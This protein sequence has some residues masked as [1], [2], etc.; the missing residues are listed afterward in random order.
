MRE[1]ADVVIIGAG[2]AG[3]A[4]ARVLDR[5]PAAASRRVL[6]LE[7][8]A[9]VGGRVATDNIDGFLLDRGFQVYL[10]AY[11]TGK[12][13]LD[14]EAL[15]LKPFA[16]GALIFMDGKLRKFV[17][18][19][20]QP[21]A[22]PAMAFSPVCSL[23]DKFRLLKL[24]RLVTSVPPEELL[25]QDPVESIDYLRRFGFSDDCIAHF[26]RPFYS[27]VF[28]EKDLTTTSRFLKYTF[29]MFARGK[30]VLPAAGM[31]AIPRQLAARL[32]HVVLELATPVIGITDKSA[33]DGGLAEQIVHTASGR[34][35]HARA[36]IVATEMPTAQRLIEGPHSMRILPAPRTTTCLYFTTTTAPTDLPLLVL[37]GQPA[38]GPINHL[39]VLTNVV[40]SYAPAKGKTRPHLISATAFTHETDDEKL[41]RQAKD[42]LTTWFG[43]PVQ[44]WTH[45]HTTRIPYALPNTDTRLAP[46]WPVD[47][48]VRPGL[49]MA[50]DSCDLPSIQGALASGKRAA[51]AITKDVLS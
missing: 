42:Q 10:T 40:P 32:R 43:Q 26:F 39:A 16:P 51:E 9:S 45:L 50:G 11:P 38:T 35:I 44:M 17:D 2:M 28:L 47:P 41:I 7:A 1:S 20:R 24:R 5:A 4:A 15:D 23:M 49:Y 21:L 30:A 22:A 29:A 8:G 31:G 27:G 36:V 33:G 37:N 18:P 3:L 19:L 48:R 14:Y 6:L 34:S 25:T 13:L 46:N 12:E